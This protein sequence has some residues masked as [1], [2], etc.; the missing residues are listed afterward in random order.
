MIHK[1]RWMVDGLE[2][3][4]EVLP[5]FEPMR[6]GTV[7]SLYLDFDK[8]NSITVRIRAE[9]SAP[10]RSDVLLELIFCDARQVS[11]PE[12]GVLDLS[13]LEIRD[14]SDR[15]LEGLHRELVNH[16]SERF[17]LLCRQ[18]KMGAVLSQEGDSLRLLW[19]HRLAR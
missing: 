18:A 10:S 11:I 4:E 5:D 1:E 2:E 16:G 8:D 14:I 9:Y 15:Q 13:E 12:L 17:S 3:L 19:E 6:L 7:R